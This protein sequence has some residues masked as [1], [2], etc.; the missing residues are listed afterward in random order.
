MHP[1]DARD[2]APRRPCPAQSAR[3]QAVEGLHGPF[4]RALRSGA[5]AEPRRQEVHRYVF[6]TSRYADFAEQV[7]S[8]RLAG[9]SEP[10]GEPVEGEAVFEIDRPFD[11]AAITAA[12]SV[13]DGTAGDDLAQRLADRFDR[14]LAGALELGE[15]HPP[16]T[17]EFNLIRRGARVLG[18]LVR[19]PESFN[20]P[21]MP[22]VELDRTVRLAAAGVPDCQAVYSKDSS[23]VFLT[24]RAGSLELPAGTYRFTFEHRLFNGE[25]YEPAGRVDDIEIEV[26]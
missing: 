4:R 16:E 13:L 15:L 14:L 20:D 22:A 18:L 26:A 6:Q 9:E 11:S 17:T 12:R 7:Y 24:D 3:P 10:G 2:R 25:A 21:K 19:S 23:Q 1:G 5:P 8:Y